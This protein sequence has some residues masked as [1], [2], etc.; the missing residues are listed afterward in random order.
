MKL[1]NCEILGRANSCMQLIS[2]Y[3]LIET[4]EEN[5]YVLQF[6]ERGNGVTLLSFC[7]LPILNHYNPTDFLTA[8][9]SIVKVS[10]LQ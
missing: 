5:F 2:D 6:S 4:L 1:L 8:N 7:F 3:T 9:S 10:S